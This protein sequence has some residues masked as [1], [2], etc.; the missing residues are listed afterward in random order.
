M[1]PQDILKMNGA[2]WDKQSSDGQSPWT[3]PVSSADIQRARQGDWALILTP[4]KPVPADWYGELRGARVLTLASGGGQQ[5]PILAAAGADV[6]SFDY[7]RVQLEKDAAVAARDGLSIRCEQ[8]DMADLSRFAADS[9]DLIFHPVSNVFARSVLPVWQES[10]RVLVRGG[11]LLAGFMNPDFYLFDH[12]AIEAG[13]DPVVRFSLPYRDIDHM[14]KREMRE[15]I[16]QGGGLEFS[17]SLQDQI[18]GQIDA[19]FTLAG[20]YEDRWSDAATPLNRH[21]PTSMATLA[22]KS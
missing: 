11:R 3:Q 7:S 14:N 13:A 19:G 8:G 18:G 21:M 15:R 12:E 5:A 20:F 17:H 10:A 16:S 6:V 22:I 4:T 1:D 2:A 9:F